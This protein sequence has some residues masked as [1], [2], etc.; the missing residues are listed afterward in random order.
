MP[1]YTDGSLDHKINHFH[2]FSGTLADA[3]LPPTHAPTA[4]PT[5]A[6]YE[7]VPT[8]YSTTKIAVDPLSFPLSA[9][10]VQ[11]PAMNY[12]LRSGFAK[13]LG[14]DIE[15]VTI[16]TI[17]GVAP[18][19]GRRLGTTNSTE[20]GFGVRSNTADAD[21]VTTLKSNIVSAGAKGALID[22]IKVEAGKA[23]VLTA[24]LKAM[25]HMIVI[26]E[27]NFATSAVEY[28]VYEP[29]PTFT[30]APT[31]VPSDDDDDDLPI[32]L[33]G[34][35]GGLA[36]LL[37]IVFVVTRGRSKSA[38]PYLTPKGGGASNV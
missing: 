8:T 4:F 23:G 26:E 35:F 20:I 25:P 37:I 7:Y 2:L 34:V 36:V 33:G 22:H 38:S 12:A 30:E 21:A 28:T 15:A 5:Y 1:S 19:S 10:D 9:D 6:G 17:D 27:A 31:P 18:A 16:D 29:A 14:F 13:A 32:I 3:P 11:A 24:D